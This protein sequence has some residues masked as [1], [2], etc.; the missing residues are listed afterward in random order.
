ML[1]DDT[2]LIRIAEKKD[3]PEVRELL[4]ETWHDTYGKNVSIE[5]LDTY[6]DTV[7]CEKN[8]ADILNEDR[9]NCFVAIQSGNIIGWMR[10]KRDDDNDI[11]HLISIYVKPHLQGKGAGKLLLD[12]GCRIAREYRFEKITLGVMAVNKKS[13]EWYKKQGFVEIRREPFTWITTTVD[14]IIMD[15]VIF[16][17]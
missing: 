17:D 16:F 6:L 2:I 14:N 8:L 11:F 9:E 13:I 10:L 1:Q 12:Q 3:L 5:E 7:Y 4:R 15:K